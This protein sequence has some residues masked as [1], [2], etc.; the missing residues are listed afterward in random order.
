VVALLLFASSPWSEA[1]SVH[2]HIN[3]IYAKDIKHTSHDKAP[4]AVIWLLPVSNGGEH[5][6]TPPHSDSFRLEQ[7]NKEFV[8]P[9]LVVP[10]GSTISFPNLDPFFHNVFSLFNGKRFDLGLYEKGQSRSVRFDRP[11]VSYI[12]C[13]IHPEMS[14][15]I[16]TLNTPYYGIVSANG[17]IN[18]GDVPPGE[19][20]LK[21]WAEGAS[22]PQL[23]SLGHRIRV[24]PSAGTDIGNISIAE[25]S[26]QPH[27]N[28]FDEDYWKQATSPY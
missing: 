15:V 12:F 24:I 10:A 11:G 8:P 6:V 19:Y 3:F 22:E 21:V 4:N 28:K 14:A 9:L 18:I 20:D 27:K 7:K 23:D 17:N 25:N 13:D 2:A 5:F 16:I 1:E 26:I